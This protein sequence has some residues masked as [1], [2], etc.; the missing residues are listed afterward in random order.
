MQTVLSSALVDEVIVVDDGS[1]DNTSEVVKAGF[2]NVKLITHPKNEGKADALL[3]AAKVARNP[4]LFFC[5]ADLIGLSED[6]IE[7]L[8][9]PVTQGEV[10]MVVGAQEFMNTFRELKLYEKIWNSTKRESLVGE[11]TKGLGGEKVI[12]K[13]DFLDV[14]GIKGSRYGVE[15]KIIAYFKE[16]RIPFKYYVLEGVRHVWKLKKWGLSKGAKKEIRAL[17]TFAKQKIEAKR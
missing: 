4:I 7:N 3:S 15:H 17:L 11:F 9:K 2:K 6:H 1:E 10:R 14:P 12:F 16:R 5:D 13:E 8:I